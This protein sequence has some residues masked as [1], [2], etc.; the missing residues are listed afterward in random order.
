MWV[1]IRKSKLTSPHCT[2]FAISTCEANPSTLPEL[3]NSRSLHAPLLTI[4]GAMPGIGL[5]P[6]E[7]I[8]Y[9]NPQHPSERH[10][11]GTWFLCFAADGR[12]KFIEAET[13]HLLRLGQQR[14]AFKT[15]QA[16]LRIFK[17]YL[18]K[19]PEDGV[20]E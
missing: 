20:I 6:L 13:V 19:L 1:D 16:P 17:Y 10:K 11:C 12:A 15:K 5:E 2:L 7:P 9:S 4:T 14:A 8:A 18:P 3:A